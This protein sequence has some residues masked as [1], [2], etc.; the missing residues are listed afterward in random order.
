MI[1]KTEASRVREWVAEAVDGGAR[2]L[3]GGGGSGA[4]VPATVLEHVPPGCQ[5]DCGEFYGPVLSLASVGSLSEAIDQAN[6]SEFGL[7]AAIFTA[8]LDHALEAVDRLEAG[9]VIVNDSTDYR[10]D[11][12]PF[13][14]VKGS[15]IGRE[16]VR[17][18]MDSMTEQR[19]VCFNR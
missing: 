12:M 18:A 17:F 9:A 1:S 5:L 2:V 15:G 13:G 14:G 8:S 10:L 11:T 19:V 6:Q 16:G 4:V 3:C 7:H